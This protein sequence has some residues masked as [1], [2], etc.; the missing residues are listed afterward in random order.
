MTAAAGRLLLAMISASVLT[1]L[2]FLMMQ[3]M[4][5]SD[6]GLND[7]IESERLV[8]FI[9][10]PDQDMLDRRRRLREPPKPPPKPPE[11]VQTPRMQVEQPPLAP[12]PKLNIAMPK[13]DLA[14]VDTGFDPAITNGVQVG[15]TVGGL[16]SKGFAGSGEV[17]P[18]V[19]IKAQYPTSALRKGIEGWVKVKFSI[20]QKGGVK[21]VRV[22]EA[23]PRRVFERSA[24]K[25]ISRWK[26]KPKLVDGVAV[27]RDG[28]LQTIRFNLPKKR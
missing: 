8:D 7:I 9:R 6:G 15:K 10:N 17:I 28:V 16:A 5:L 11:P 18:L 25:A 22:V 4:V 2:L 24:I 20:N 14:R 3:R 26:F 12:L 23:Q 13:L 19:R 27:E 21:N 1:L